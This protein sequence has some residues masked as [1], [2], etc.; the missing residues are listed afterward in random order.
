MRY[1][2]SGKLIHHTVIVGVALS[3]VALLVMN[4]CMLLM[5]SRLN[6]HHHQTTAHLHRPFVLGLSGYSGAIAE[7]ALTGVIIW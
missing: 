5:L 1:E 6:D 7:G 4:G 2:I 3:Y